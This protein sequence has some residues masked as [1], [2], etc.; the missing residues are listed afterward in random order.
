MSAVRKTDVPIGVPTIVYARLKGQNTSEFEVREN[1]I[2]L[3]VSLNGYFT[4]YE[5]F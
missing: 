3:K 4:H 5:T 2:I 1:S